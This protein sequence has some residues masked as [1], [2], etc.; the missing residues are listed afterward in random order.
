MVSQESRWKKFFG[1]RLFLVIAFIIA[2][3]VIFGY[4]RAYFQEYQ[5]QQEIERLQDE[6]R[7]LEG[8]KIELLEVLKYV[9][10]TD[11]VEEKARS[12]FNM[13]KPGEQVAI[14]SSTLPQKQHGQEKANMIAWSNISNYAKWWKYFFGDEKKTN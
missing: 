8:K 14:I 13:V 3:M 6:A 5:V 4:G 12:E 10:S 11:F 9:K 7:N 1:S 2:F